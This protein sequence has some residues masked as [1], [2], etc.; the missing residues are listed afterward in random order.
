MPC[1]VSRVAQG[2]HVC[3]NIGPTGRVWMSH[4]WSACVGWLGRYGL[5]S[6]PCLNRRYS[7]AGQLQFDFAMH[8][9][10][11]R[12]SSDACPSIQGCMQ[13]A[14]GLCNYLS[15]H[16]PQAPLQPVRGQGQL[17]GQAAYQR[18]CQLGAAW[19]G[20][21]IGS[22]L[23]QT[24]SDTVHQQQPSLARLGSVLSQAMQNQH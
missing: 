5:L 14:Q 4:L 7:G 10:Q 1:G 15:E 8:V 19:C 2:F 11:I 17:Q 9:G 16:C 13:C 18:L 20:P 3:V 6:C 23:Q 24:H 12:N 21:V 22:N